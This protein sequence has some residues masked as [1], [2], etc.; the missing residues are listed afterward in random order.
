MYSG[1]ASSLTIIESSWQRSENKRKDI[2]RELWAKRIILSGQLVEAEV[3]A[4][5]GLLALFGLGIGRSTSTE[6]HAIAVAACVFNG[7]HLYKSACS[8]SDG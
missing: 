5:A 4:A 3:T 7:V 8:T 2:N 6:M 1:T